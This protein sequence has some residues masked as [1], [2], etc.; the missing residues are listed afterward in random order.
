MLASP[1]LGAVVDPTDRPRVDAGDAN[2]AVAVGRCGVALEPCG[3][4]ADEH[5]RRAHEDG[6]AG[7]SASAARRVATASLSCSIGAST[8]RRMTWASTR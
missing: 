4:L 3:D 1:Y 7:E 6:S 2:G 5:D 8:V